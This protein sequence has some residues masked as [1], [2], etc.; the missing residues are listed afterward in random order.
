MGSC[1]LCSMGWLFD[2]PMTF[3]QYVQQ[4]QS[5]AVGASVGPL[6][7]GAR[8]GVMLLVIPSTVA[9]LAL[10]VF[11]LG[12]QSEKPR[13]AWGAL[14]VSAGLTV[15]MFFSGYLLW[16]GGAGVGW[17]V[18]H[19][20]VLVVS[21]VLTGFCVPAL[22]QILHDPPPPGLQ[23]VTDAELAEMGVV[24][25][26]LLAAKTSATERE[27]ARRKARIVA[28]QRRL[29]ELERRLDQR[30]NPPND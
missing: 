8:S 1:C 26:D 7:Q 15:V 27:V 29:D 5:D 19:G 4:A 17:L 23:S 22:V 18:L 10:A 12:L 20:V 24:P 2:S 30:K 9:G 3:T 6:A 21:L 14:S 16:S 28:E 11:G 25:D 13:A